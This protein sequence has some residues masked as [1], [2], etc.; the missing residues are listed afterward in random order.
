[1][2]VGSFFKKSVRDLFIASPQGAAE[3]IVWRY[4][5]QAIPF[6]AKVT[7]RSDETAVFF[8]EGK[9]MGVLEAGTYPIDSKNIP[10]ITELFVSSLTGDN[11]YLTELFFVRR[12]EVLHRIE[13]RELGA[14]SD[15]GSRLLVTLLFNTRFGVRVHR[16]VALIE[17]L[18]GQRATAGEQVKAWIDGR[19]GSLLGAVVGQVMADEPVTRLVSNQYSE[20]IGQA[21]IEQAH[22]LF[23]AEGLE[24]TRFVDLRLRLAEDSRRA[25]DEVSRKMATLALDRE[26]AELARDPG[27]AQ[28]HLVQ[29]Q[30]AMLEGIGKGAA[31][32]TAMPM[33]AL[34][35]LGGGFLPLPA[36]PTFRPVRDPT[37]IQNVG[38]HAPR[39]VTSAKRYYLRSG[40]GVEGPYLARQMI[41]RAEALG[42]ESAE[43]EVRQEGATQWQ[44]LDQID[45]LAEAWAGRQDIRSGP[46]ANDAKN[47]SHGFEAALEVALSDGV[48]TQEELALLVPLVRGAGLASDEASARAYV[49]RRARA[50]GA[51]V[52]EVAPDAV[53]GASPPPLPVDQTK[54]FSYSNGASQVDGLTAEAVA[55]R[56][57]ALPDGVHLVW[58]VGMDGWKSAGEVHEIAALL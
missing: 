21:V 40:R 30:R 56:V 12:T 39:Q 23:D 26:G 51:S 38:V 7:V 57:R 22:R 1:M 9:S 46:R 49:V 16:P 41:V 28:Y 13:E 53:G 2:G 32:G 11:H 48:L 36:A 25:L 52:S 17:L 42:L 18:A 10:F 55:R 27:Y 37:P 20:Q 29:G 15:L 19:V 35:P 4:P 8:R 45:E 33:M 47:G 44:V 34:P 58:R 24:I 50:H 6:G 31:S 14:Y 54:V 5:E 3:S 43:I